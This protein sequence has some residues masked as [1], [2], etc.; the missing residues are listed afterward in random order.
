MKI[1]LK[2][3]RWKQIAFLSR[4]R[5]FTPAS[6]DTKLIFDAPREG[7]AFYE[8]NTSSVVDAVRLLLMLPKGSYYKETEPLSGWQMN[9]L[10]S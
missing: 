6:A 4:A 10:T 2:V 1:T 8:V 3:P 9:M 7:F 5:K